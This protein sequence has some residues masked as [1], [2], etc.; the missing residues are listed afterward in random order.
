MLKYKYEGRKYKYIKYI[1]SVCTSETEK[2][3]IA[4]VCS[5]S[6]T[7][8]QSVAAE[9]YSWYEMVWKVSSCRKGASL[10]RAEVPT[11]TRSRLPLWVKFVIWMF[12]AIQNVHSFPLLFYYQM[13]PALREKAWSTPTSLSRWKCNTSSVF[14]SG[15]IPS[16]QTFQWRKVSCFLTACPPVLLQG[17]PTTV[18]QNIWFIYDELWAHLSTV[19]RGY[20]YATYRERWIRRGRHVT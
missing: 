5:F 18:P 6:S 15:P 9:L 8:T 3:A 19:V 1:K 11:P 12:D 2:L 20:L 14:T 13:K 10:P 4:K 7:S 17:T 16:V